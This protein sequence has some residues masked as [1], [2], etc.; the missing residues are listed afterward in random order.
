MR[1]ASNA[2]FAALA[3]LM[4]LPANAQQWVN[5]YVQMVEDYGGF[6]SGAQGILVTLT[7][8]A[9]GAAP[10]GETSG[11]TNCWQR[12]HINAGIQGVNE[13]MKDRMFSMLITATTTKRRVGLF[14]Y[15]ATGP[16]C[17]VQIVSYGTEG[18]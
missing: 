8:M 11:A 17:E 18:R 1:F 10:S 6:Q 3:I 5:G 16:Y 4:P 9:W 13:N 12:F 14:V 7:D 2:F 15:P